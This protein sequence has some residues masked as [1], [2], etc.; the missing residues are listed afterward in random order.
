MSFLIPIARS[1]Y[2]EF[3]DLKTSVY[4]GYV[5]VQANPDS[6]RKM[7]YYHRVAQER[8]FLYD[9]AKVEGS[10]VN[11]A[12]LFLYSEGFAYAQVEKDFHD[13]IADRKSKDPNYI[14]ELLRVIKMGIK[15]AELF[16]K[17][18][19]RLIFYLPDDYRFIIVPIVE[20]PSIPVGRFFLK[21]ISRQSLI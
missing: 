8:A 2:K 11:H 21:T 15:D 18:T 7:L 1:Y 13:A 16:G 14:R 10:Y 4:G 9:W 6:F 12:G 20:N 3:N 19:P 5:Y 17:K